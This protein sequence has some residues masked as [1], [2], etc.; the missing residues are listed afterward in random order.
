M[1]L[2]R[3]DP[4]TDLRIAD[5]GAAG[6]VLNPQS[7]ETHRLHEGLIVT[8]ALLREKARSEEELVAIFGDV[9]AEGKSSR[10]WLDEAL[11]TLESFSLVR[12]G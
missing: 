6:M 5:F 3:L 9:T 2:W 11:L 7:W 12:R 10:S 1:A 8:L 4:S